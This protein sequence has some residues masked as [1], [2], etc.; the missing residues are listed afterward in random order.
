MTYESIGKEV[1]CKE[2]RQYL[3]RRCYTSNYLARRCFASKYL[4]G[5]CFARN[6][7]VIRLNRVSGPVNI[8]AN[9]ELV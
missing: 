9:T 8:T 1:P 7:F 6:C 3:A 5:R 2:A 4:A